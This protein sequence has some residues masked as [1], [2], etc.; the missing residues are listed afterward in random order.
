MADKVGKGG[1][2]DLGC[3]RNGMVEQQAPI[4]E[5]TLERL[6]A[7]QA[8]I[9]DEYLADN[10]DPWII[11]YSGGKDSTLVTQ[12]VFEML[13][14]L[15]PSD[16]TR[17][18]HILCNDTLVESPVL[19]AYIDAMLTR[20]QTA[21]ESLH[22]PIT[23]VKTTPDPD[24]TF[25]VNLIGRGYPAPTRMFRWCT[26]RMKIAPTSN[27][28]RSQISQ[29]G[30]VVLLLGVRRAES[31]N[32]AV[33]VNRHRNVAGTRLN[34]HDDMRGCMVFRPIIDMTTDDV[35]LL[36]LQRQPPWGGSHRDLVTL[37]RNA[38]G[39]ECPLVMD[40]SQAP[41][42]GTSSSRFGCWTCT[43]V[44]KDRSMEAMIDSGHEHLE[45]LMDFR[46]WLAKFRN[47][48]SKR[49]IERR[50]GRIALMGDGVTTV[51]GPFTVEARQ[52]ILSRLLQVQAEV[53][54][55]LI[56]DDEIARIR[57]I[58]ASDAVEEAKRHLKQREQLRREQA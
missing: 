55:P 44:E 33:T 46:D 48:R 57:A 2:P 58:W 19:M 43:V 42:C 32:R 45:P 52:E 40:K 7:A 23:V 56:R 11:G 20:L 37:Y 17:P 53:E 21:A 18:V 22:L 1:I 29:N 9:R 36:L 41:S 4:T 38:Q 34:P 31:A 25:W 30:E 3:G 26:D 8:D 39:G 13:L 24:Q 35:W 12:L 49:M 16:R 27:Y 5:G 54:M 50:D 47:E 28:I 6:R 10:R 14:D 51:A 15:A